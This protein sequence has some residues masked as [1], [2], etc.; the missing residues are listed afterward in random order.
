MIDKNK[1]YLNCHVV[2]GKAFV[3]FVNPREDEQISIALTFLKN[4]YHTKLVSACCEFNFDEIFNFDFDTDN[5][6]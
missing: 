6:N 3:D 2:C 1:R 4:R 5:S